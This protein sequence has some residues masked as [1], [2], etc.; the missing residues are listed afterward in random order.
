LRTNADE[1]PD[2]HTVV[3][4]I[5]PGEQRALRVTAER[6]WTLARIADALVDPHGVA[7]T[8]IAVALILAWRLVA[9]DERAPP[10]PPGRSG[11]GAAATR[12]P[13]RL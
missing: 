5:A 10:L 1:R 11:G 12:P 4:N 6:P 8:F 7:A 9:R 2:D 3:W 13:A